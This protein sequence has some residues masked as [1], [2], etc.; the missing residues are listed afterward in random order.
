MLHK[1]GSEATAKNGRRPVIGPDSAEKRAGAQPGAP[2]L[3]FL[4]TFPGGHAL[5]VMKH[6]QGPAARVLEQG[7]CGAHGQGG[8][9]QHELSQGTDFTGGLP[10]RTSL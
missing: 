7:L 5:L 10:G 6:E 8:M 3:D 9:T 2:P 1:Y 4:A